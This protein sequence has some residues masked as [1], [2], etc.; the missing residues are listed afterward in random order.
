MWPDVMSSWVQALDKVCGSR[1]TP[2]E[3]DKLVALFVY[4]A[5]GGRGTWEVIPL[6]TST[7]GC[8]VKLGLALDGAL[9]DG[10]RKVVC[11]LDFASGR[12][13]VRVCP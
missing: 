8:S 6:W 9:V 3:K 1:L 2:R 13:V 11:H 10:G 7:R 12:E 5:A 4:Q